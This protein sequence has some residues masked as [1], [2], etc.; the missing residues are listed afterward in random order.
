MNIIV[1]ATGRV[2]SALVKELI[3]RGM[4]VTAVVRD[5]NKVEMFGKEVQV[6]I[7][8]LFD[9]DTLAKAFEGGDTAFLITPENMHSQDVIEDAKKVIENYRKAVMTSGIKRVVGLSSMGAGLGEGSGNLYISYLLERAFA[10]LPVQTT[11]IR[12]AYYYSNW[13][14]YL[15][16]AR[17]YG[18]LPTFFNPTQKIAMVAPEDVARF[19][20]TVMR[21]HALSAPVYEI[22]GPVEYSSGDMAQ[23]FSQYLNREVVA[24][25]T[26]YEQWI[27]TLTSV[28]FSDDAARNMALMTET[29]VNTTVFGE[30]PADLIVWNTDMK[31][32]L[33]SL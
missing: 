17:E 30:N 20:A 4:P 8:D 26:P 25:Q 3:K 19:V 13:V 7:S 9:A 24:R 6:R 15:E 33:E 1:G 16:L 14:G 12:P 28:G 11:F 23:F 27:P 21:S 29:V 22:T 2:G 31:E 10:D 5:R 32:Y 18:I